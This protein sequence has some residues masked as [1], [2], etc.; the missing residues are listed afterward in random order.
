MLVALTAAGA[1]VAAP[2]AGAITL[3]GTV[4]RVVDGDTVTV[5]SRGFETPVRL[6]G[7]DTPET[8]HPSK[9]VQCLGP[10][11]SA[12]ASRLLPAGQRVRL[13]TD[14]TQDTRDR[15][16]RLLAY[17]YKPGGA[18]AAG[19]INFRLI[20]SGHAKVYVY[21]GVRFAHA[22]TFL[23]EQSRARTRS[24]GSG[25]RPA[26]ATPGARIRA[27]AGRHPTSR[28][29]RPA[30]ATELR[31][32]LRAAHLVRPRLRRHRADRE[33]GRHRPPSLRRRRRRVG[34]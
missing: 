7:I 3:D 9:P 19:S 32:R 25:A 6:I 31:G 21:G 2:A 8:R 12:Q 24:G 30:R 17:V 33:G 11:A 18:G 14:D 16:G 5:V 20:R 13:V 22:V 4:S 23:R 29:P 1:G 15:Y 10:A 26:E 28:D 27:S 34:L